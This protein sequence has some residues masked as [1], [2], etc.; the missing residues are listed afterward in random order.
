MRLESFFYVVR[1]KD[2][3]VPTMLR[4]SLAAAV[5]AAVSDSGELQGFSTTQF[6]NSVM[7]IPYLWHNRDICC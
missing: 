2:F 7:A 1:W 4:T 3:P 6:L 5:S